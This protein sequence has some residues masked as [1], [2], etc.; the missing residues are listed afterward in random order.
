M[1]ETSPMINCN[2]ANSSTGYLLQYD[3]SPSTRTR[4]IN[5][6]RRQMKN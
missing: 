6:L 4:S 2:L 3:V 5:H 1:I